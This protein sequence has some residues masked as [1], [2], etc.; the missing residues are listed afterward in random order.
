MKILFVSDNYPPE[1]NAPASRTFEHCREWSKA[2]HEVSVLT[3]SPNFP[4]GKLFAGYKNSLYKVEKSQGIRII[5]VW[6]FISANEG[7]IKRTIDHLSFAFTSFIFGLFQDCD[8]IIGTSPQFF[9]ALTIKYLSK[10]KK[11][12]CILEIRDLWPDSIRGLGALKDG[13]L[14]KL[15]SNLELQCYKTADLIIVVTESFREEIAKR[16]INTNKIKVVK[17]GAN[18]ELFGRI[19]KNT[20]LRRKFC[21]ENKFLVGYIGTH[22]MAH[23][24]DFIIR[25]ISK[26]DPF[27][28]HFIFIGEGSE[29]NKLIQLSMNLK[30]T[31]IKFIDAVSKEN[32]PDY[33]SITD[34]V[35]IPLRRLKIY[36][37][38]IPSKI[39]ESAAMQKPIL[40]GVDG[41]ARQI[42][43]KYKSGIY[44]QPENEK[45]LRAGLI[46]LKNDKI[47]YKKC[48]YGC[49]DLANNYNRKKLALEMLQHIEDLKN[50]GS[51]EKSVIPSHNIKA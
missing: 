26:L 49:K 45:A 43:E 20:Q 44:F 41:E 31:N 13:F 5:R 24:L 12:P 2:G 8:V 19:S 39:F 42:V 27:E 40:L 48:T 18:L 28:F 14:I 6:S 32:V 22:G 50:N 9:V 15:L 3:C 46:K 17:N 35:M 36:T 4:R 29:K 23:G 16:G 38:V 21:S 33:I 10:F 47:L 34:A 30:C 11:K 25:A 1:V 37:Q 7:I 51:M